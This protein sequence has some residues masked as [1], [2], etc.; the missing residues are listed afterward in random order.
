MAVVA[1]VSV[2]FVLSTAFF[3][4]TRTGAIFEPIIRWF[5]PS[6]SGQSLDVAHGL[7]RKAA[8]FVMYGVLFFLLIRGPLRGREGL[9]LLVCV[10]VAFGD[11]GHQMLVPGRKGSL[12][13]VALNT[14]GALF[15]RFLYAAAN[16]VR[17]DAAIPLAEPTR[18]SNVQ[19]DG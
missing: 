16:E 5:I 4:P 13:D 9:A 18:F 10:A 19:G 11:E 15:A 8:H 1:W 2:L 14:T 3:S 6:I 12:Y 17:Y 7:I